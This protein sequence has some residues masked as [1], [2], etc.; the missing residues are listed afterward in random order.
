M[1]PPEPVRQASSDPRFA[2]TRWSLV[3]AASASEPDAGRRALGE[4]CRRYWYPVYSFVRRCGHEPFVAQGITRR[5]FARLL[6]QRLTL[7]GPQRGRF[8]EYLLQALGRHLAESTRP[9]PAT[10]AILDF[11]PPQSWDEMEARHRA[12]VSGLLTPEQAYQRS[13]ALELLDHAMR[14]L[15]AEAQQA[16]HARMFEA[17]APWLAEEPGPG[18]FEPLAQALGLRPLAVVVALKRLRQRFRELAEQE[19]GETVSSAEDLASEREALARAL[20]DKVR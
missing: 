20:Q 14:R 15:Q 4:L 8:R 13:Y 2:A 3:A 6:D 12:D 19:L 18:G 9:P 11:E 17:L 1:N 7:P 10:A 16:G 5:F